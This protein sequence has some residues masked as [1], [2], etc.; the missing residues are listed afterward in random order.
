MNLV[1]LEQISDLLRSQVE[2]GAI[3]GGSAY[4]LKNGRPIFR[5]NAGMADEA[6]GIKWTND[7]IVRLYSLTK[8]ITAAAAMILLDR[9]KLDLL[10]KV[11]WYIPGFRNQTVLTENGREPVHTEVSIKDLLNMTSGLCYP[12]RS[13]PAGSVMQDLYDGICDEG[14]AGKP[15][16]TMEYANRIGQQPLAFQPGERWLYGTSADV[17]GAVIECV[18]GEKFG[19]FLRKELF[20]PLGMKDT[21]FWCPE[22]KLDRFA[23]NYEE[24][25]GR[26]E[27]CMW[28]HLG[29]TYLCRKPPEFQSGGAGLCSTMDDYAA[30]AEMLLNE[31]VYNG[32]RILSRNAV[33]YMTS[34]QL[35]QQQFSSCDWEQ[36]IGYGYGNLMRVAT[37]EYMPGISIHPGEYGW[38]GWL[39]CFWANDPANGYTFLYFIQRCGGMGSRPI[40]LIKQIVYGSED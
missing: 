7:T 4:V 30:F 24:K 28:Q 1:K 21:D 23:E 20:E 37:E 18:S 6:R 5:M 14:A 2:S 40:R 8:P 36:C 13:F 39:G 26:L 31:G 27:P 10:D 35:S 29:L 16:D 22:D 25:D 3:K 11:S 38:D 19:D 15:V 12:D 32:R 34:N 9:G 33:R 17:L